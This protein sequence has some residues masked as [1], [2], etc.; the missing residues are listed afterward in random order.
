MTTQEFA[1]LILNEIERLDLAYT[2]RVQTY[3]TVHELK[4]FIHNNSGKPKIKKPDLPE[5]LDCR[6]DM[7][8]E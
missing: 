4:Y 8:I 7:R 2:G 3:S 5:F 6:E 1:D